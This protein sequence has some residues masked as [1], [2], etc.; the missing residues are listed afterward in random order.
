MR[1]AQAAVSSQRAPWAA[2]AAWGWQDS[3]VGW[4]GLEHGTS[5]NMGLG[6]A[7]S[8]YAVVALPRGDLLILKALGAGDAPG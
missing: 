3:P 1:E 5:H 2:V 6:G 8:A 4:L 7:C